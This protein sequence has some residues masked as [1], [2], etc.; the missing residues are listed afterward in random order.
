[1]SKVFGLQRISSNEFNIPVDPRKIGLILGHRRQSQKYISKHFNTKIT[2]FNT[3]GNTG[4]NVFSKN[5][6]DLWD[7]I[8][9]IQNK[10][11]YSSEHPAVTSYISMF[12]CSSKQLCT[13]GLILQCIETGLA[14][15]LWVDPDPEYKQNYI[16]R[17]RTNIDFFNKDCPESSTQEKTTR[18]IIHLFVQLLEQNDV[19][20]E[21]CC[22]RNRHPDDDDDPTNCRRCSYNYI[23]QSTIIVRLLSLNTCYLRY[24]DYNL[25]TQVFF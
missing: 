13:A 7:T 20:T 21:C 23:L 18:Y 17:I 9:F 3:L 4:F 16:E 1:M 25:D 22:D 8:N 24:I 12:Y 6:I 14:V 15:K 2:V 11:Y 5:E 10:V 19:Y